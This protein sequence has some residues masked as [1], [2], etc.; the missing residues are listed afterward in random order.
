MH[1]SGS[2]MR[3]QCNVR[4]WGKSVVVGRRQH[5]DSQTAASAGR[6]RR[7]S[8]SSSKC[9][10]REA[11]FRAA[12]QSLGLKIRVNFYPRRERWELI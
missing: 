9:R 6:E 5:I 1:L 7:G 3:F 10:T 4:S 11:Y 12:V 8:F 2:W